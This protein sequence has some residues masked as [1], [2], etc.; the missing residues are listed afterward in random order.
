[1]KRIALGVSLLLLS[2]A[3]FAQR[4]AEPVS[5]NGNAFLAECAKSDAAPIE[6]VAFVAGVTEGIDMIQQMTN[7]KRLCVPY[8]VPYGQQLRIVVKY[9]QDHPNELQLQTRLLIF[10]AMDEAFPC[11]PSARPH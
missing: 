8:D 3:C 7:V 11:K 4:S 5:T 9:G 1:M 2:G 10:K 6:C